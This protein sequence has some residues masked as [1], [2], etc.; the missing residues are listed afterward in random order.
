MNAIGAVLLFRSQIE[1]HT[2]LK[3][4]LAPSPLKEPG[5]HVK[6]V[7]RKVLVPERPKA[8]QN[9][10]EVRLYVSID[11]SVESDTGLALALSACET[12][13]AYLTTCTRLEDEH[14]EQIA[15]TRVVSTANEDDGILQDPDNGNLAWLDDLHFVT[16]SIP[17]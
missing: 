8:A 5:V 10:H 14:G 16:L 9:T 12:L 17:A 3:V 15:N 2:G 13:G 6:I 4:I 7:V 1:R 11:G